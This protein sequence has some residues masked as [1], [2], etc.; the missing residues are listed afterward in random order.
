MNSVFDAAKLL[1]EQ[2]AIRIPDVGKLEL[3]PGVTTQQQAVN[4]IRLIIDGVERD[5]EGGPDAWSAVCA[6]LVELTQP[7]QAALATSVD[8][9]SDG[10]RD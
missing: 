2:R 3:D 9:T 10:E 7:D 8:R 1:F 6:A 5:F 4:G